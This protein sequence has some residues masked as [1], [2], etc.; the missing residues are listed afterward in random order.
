MLCIV[1]FKNL[2]VWFSGWMNC[3]A[4]GAALTVQGA[5]CKSTPC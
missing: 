3:K 4:R 5:R 1:E 2:G